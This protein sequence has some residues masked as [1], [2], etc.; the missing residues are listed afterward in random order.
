MPPR[1]SGTPRGGCPTR[2]RHGISTSG[3]GDAFAGRGLFSSRQRHLHH[4]GSRI[5][6]RHTYGVIDRA[7]SRLCALPHPLSREGIFVSAHRTRMAGSRRAAALAVAAVLGAT[8]FAN[9]SRR[10]PTPARRTP[11]RPASRCPTSSRRSGA[12][13]RSRRARPR[14]RTRRPL[15]G[16]YGYYNDGPM[17]PAP[18]RRAGAGPQR[19]GDQERA[20]Q[21]HL[22][23]RQR[24]A[25]RRPDV[26]LRHALPLPGPR[27]RHGRGRATSRASTSTPMRRTG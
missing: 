2:D 6:A 11:R 3:G 12:R 19:R 4:S 22:S 13:P 17:V 9:S 10:S 7:G 16:Y 20:R 21:E 25:R 1:D 5:R 14:S 15:T 24:P 27:A 26:R 8:T 23:R 18:G